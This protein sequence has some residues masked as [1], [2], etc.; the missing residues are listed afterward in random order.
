MRER[1]SNLSVLVRCVLEFLLRGRAVA[2]IAKPKTVVV[3]QF[4]KLGD[5]VCTT[6]MFRAI[7]KEY[8]DARIIVVGDKVGGQVLSGNSYVDRYISCGVH[9]DG[10]LE[11]LQRENPDVGI[12]VGPSVRAFGLLYLAGASL[13]IAPRVVG[14]INSESRIY[15]ILRRFGAIASHHVGQYAPREYLRL[16]EPLGI[17]TND[18]QKH[19]AY[20]EEAAASVDALLKE[21]EVQKKN[22][23]GIAPSAGNKIKNWP[24]QRFALVA[25]HLSKKYGAVIML[26]GGPSD[27][28]ESDEVR[29]FL[30]PATECIDTTGKLS[31]EELKALIARLKLF[32]S[33]DTGPIYIAE[34][35]GVPTVDIVGPMDERE[36]PPI[37]EKHMVVIPPYKR[38]PQLFIMSPGVKDR[39]EARR[40]IESITA[41]QVIEVVDTLM[42]RIG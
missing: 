37:G 35:L 34:A 27:K 9:I 1:F 23:I 14:E 21:N 15:R 4:G 19:V 7:K 26:L 25:D 2:K 31:L 11:E 13:V 33:V 18:T 22:L 29:S 30:G 3:V 10:A 41:E 36:Q 38:V 20:T 42:S 8:P 16:L 5:M 6:P 40:Q 12:T 24:A 32:I 28:T 39:V 17:E